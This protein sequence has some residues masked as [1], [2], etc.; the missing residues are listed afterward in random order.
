M[1]DQIR[2]FLSESFFVDDIA[3]EASF[4]EQGVLDSTGVLE[5]V[6]FLEDAFGIDVLDE[7]LLPDNLDSVARIVRFVER[8]QLAVIAA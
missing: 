5:L 2:R 8:K 7:E 4:L 6:T 1:E 3:A